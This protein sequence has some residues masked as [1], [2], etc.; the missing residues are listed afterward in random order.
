M[1]HP[2]DKE[3]EELITL[4]EDKENFLEILARNDDLIEYYP[5]EINYMV[6]GRVW[7]SWYPSSFNIVG[8]CYFF[9]INGEVIIIDPG[10]NAIDIL[11]RNKVDLRLIRHL[12]VTHFHP[13]HF[14]SLT[15]LLTR[16]ISDEIKL[17]VYLN[18]TTFQQFKIYAKDDLK[19]I[20]LKPSMTLNLDFLKDERILKMKERTFD[21]ELK[22]GKAFHREIGGAVGSIGLK[23]VLKHRK[24]K[25]EFKIGIMS[26]TDGSQDYMEY[27]RNFYD[28]CN[29]LIPHIGAVHK[30]PKG[31]K[32]LYL[33]GLEKLLQT[34]NKN[35]KFV[36]LSE[37]GLELGS[38]LQFSELVKELIPKDMNYRAFVQNLF[39]IQ[40]SNSLSR[41]ILGSVL[42]H[43]IESYLGVIEFTGICIELIL[44]LIG[45]Y[46]NDTDC[47][48]EI[49]EFKDII[50]EMYKVD[51]A[52]T[53]LK[54]IWKIFLEEHIFKVSN[55]NTSLQLITETIDK[56][57]A[58]NF[59]KKFDQFISNL[60]EFSSP[61]Y[62]TSLYDT[63]LKTL[64]PRM[65]R[66]KFYEL[67]ERYRLIRIL[68]NVKE[69]NYFEFWSPSARERLKFG[70][71]GEKLIH[72]Y[73]ESNS[74]ISI[75]ESLVILLLFYAYLLINLEGLNEQI[76]SFNKKDG[77][78]TT[79][80]YLC[81]KTGWKIYP[82]H[83]SFRIVFD[84]NEIFIEGSCT[85]PEH[86]ELIDIKKF[87]NKWQ[88]YPKKI[89]A[90]QKIQEEY[91]NVIP[92][93]EC[94][95]CKFDDYLSKIS[96]PD[97]D[98]D[99]YDADEVISIQKEER[100]YLKEASAIF[101]AELEA[102][103]SKVKT[104]YDFEDLLIDSGIVF[105]DLVTW[106]I[107][108]ELEETTRAKY[109]ELLRTDSPENISITSS[110]L[111]PI[112]LRIDEIK[113]QVLF[114]L[115]KVPQE[116][117]LKLFRMMLSVSDLAILED[118]AILDHMNT[119]FWNFSQEEKLDAVF[120]LTRVLTAIRKEKNPPKI[121]K[122]SSMFQEYFVKTI[123]PLI[124]SPKE[125]IKEL[126]K[127]RM[128]PT[129]FLQNVQ[130][131]GHPFS[132]YFLPLKDSIEYLIANF[133]DGVKSIHEKQ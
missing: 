110:L 132:E 123:Y 83:P 56:F 46:R 73:P 127:I 88:F 91:I 80:S 13:D 124:E 54:E 22:I 97:Y 43:R 93:S 36:F 45:F 71:I 7:N 27:Y 9:N 77:R 60:L 99:P 89:L 69:S 129:D 92:R 62:T 44:P 52:E 74:V 76:S 66:K 106:G 35:G 100:E 1:T 95:E 111:D 121:T 31:Y 20:E 112:L 108:S 38:D 10:F 29:I 119:R 98:Y 105:S 68:R 86:R 47:T 42:N 34:F 8:G 41:T 79:C 78:K 59:R 117:G 32:H 58:E 19:L 128:A 11:K 37:F 85:K 25:K 96:S 116:N 102:N 104:I 50:G 131:L 53:K 23:F 28:D 125:N 3:M 75:K 122:I 40:D 87:Y 70:G 15:R 17:N 49:E 115:R 114:R 14:E 33:S 21:V 48:Q 109:I 64:I 126:L 84:S 82:G 90:N 61:N 6:L 51:F 55:S 67:G 72:I 4:S 107:W 113:K 133:K 16:E 5:Q 12:I 26:D 24:T 39:K 130:K 103:P 65:S 94:K 57:G 2:I 118:E 81:N 30:H 63:I 18:P 101:E 120:T